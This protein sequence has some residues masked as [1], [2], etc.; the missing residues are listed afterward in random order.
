MRDSEKD[1]R[2]HQRTWSRVEVFHTESLGFKAGPY[3]MDFAACVYVT[4]L[5][6]YSNKILW[7]HASLQ[8]GWGLRSICR[9][10][11]PTV[12]FIFT[13][14]LSSEIEWKSNLWILSFRMFQVA[15]SRSGGVCRDTKHMRFCVTCAWVTFQG[16]ECSSYTGMYWFRSNILSHVGV[17]I[18][19]VCIDDRI[20]W[21]LTDYNYK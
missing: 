7:F 6:T 16:P 1:A 5:P 13:T 19:G 17:T 10:P 4:S 3:V 9:Y 12:I 14:I 18:D 8:R 21:T 11:M 15:R 20:Y 2:N